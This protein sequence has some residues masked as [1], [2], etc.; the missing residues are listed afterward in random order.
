MSEDYKGP[1]KK[2]R[3]AGRIVAG[4]LDE[5]AKIAKPGVRTEEIDNCVIVI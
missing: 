3:I 1:L 5:V 2:T 4:A